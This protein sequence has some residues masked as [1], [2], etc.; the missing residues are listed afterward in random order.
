EH[1]STSPDSQAR[2][3]AVEHDSTS[4]SNAE[5]A[6]VTVW[7]GAL[8]DGFYVEDD[9]PGIP[10]DERAEVF[11]PGYT[12]ATRGTGFGLHIVEQIAEAHDWDASITSGRAGGARFEFHTG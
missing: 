5:D 2:Q 10:P 7:I 4:P 12:T 11:D 6:S 1:G 9:G 3:D 8:E